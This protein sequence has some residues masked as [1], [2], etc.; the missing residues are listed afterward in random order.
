[1]NFI[2]F[3]PDAKVL[4]RPTVFVFDDRFNLQ[5]RFLARKAIYQ[6][7]GWKTDGA[8]SRSDGGLATRTT[9]VDLPMLA[10]DPEYFGREYRQPSQ[11]T[12]V[13]LRHYITTL[14]AAGYRV[15]RLQVQLHQ[16]I[17][18]PLSLVILAWLSLSF[19][20]RPGHRGTL[21]GV[22]LALV[23]GMAYFATLAFST[24]LGEASMISPLLAAWTPNVVF[25]LWAAN[26][27]TTLQT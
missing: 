2:E 9:P 24:R 25:A 11:M 3:D 7:G 18:Y 15:D 13:E 12:F 26:R 27:H 6:N 8:W 19:A 17:A 4:I 14:S 10:V 22:A 21:M 1:M 16:R 5:F 20:F 23:L